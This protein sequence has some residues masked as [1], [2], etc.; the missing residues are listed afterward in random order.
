MQAMVDFMIFLLAH[1][2]LAQIVFNCLYRWK[3]NTT[4]KSDTTHNRAGVNHPGK[5]VTTL[6]PLMKCRLS[7]GGQARK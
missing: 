4:H 6:S 5:T 1:T 3:K 2:S 7:G